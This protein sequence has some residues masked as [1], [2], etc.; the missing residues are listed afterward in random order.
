M[1]GPWEDYQSIASNSDNSGPWND[2]KS[3]D[4]G[5]NPQAAVQGFGQFATAGYLPELTSAAGKLMTKILPDP[6]ADIDA[7]LRAQGTNIQQAPYQGVTTDESRALQ[8]NLASQSPGSYYGGGALGAVA[9][10]PAFGAALKGMGL[11]KNLPTAA[12]ALSTLPEDASLLAKAGTY[13]ANLGSRAIQAGKEGVVLGALQNPNTNP[14]EQGVNPG[15]RIMNAATSGVISSAIPAVGD[16]IKGT[17]QAIKSGTQWGLTK[18]LS[19]IGG[20]NPDTINEYAQYA[21]RI[22]S[23]PNVEQLKQTSDEFV[24]KLAADVDAKK[25]SQQQAQ[26]AYNGFKNDLQDAYKTLTYDARD[27]ITSAKQTLQDTHNT[28]IQ[29]I[30]NDVYDSVNQ[31]RSDVKQGSANA[32]KTLG[33]SNAMVDLAP[34]YASID[35]SISNLK[36]ANTD[37]ALSAAQALQNYKDR[38]VSKFGDKIPAP[39]A[40]PVIQGL[41]K[42]TSYNSNPST[43][44]DVRN[45]AFKGIRG[46]LDETLKSAVPEYG[47]AMVP[48]AQDTALL[49]QVQPFG[50]KQTAVGLLNRLDNPNQFQ[51]K[52]ALQQL[53]SKYNTD[54]VSAANPQNLPEYRLLQKAQTNLKNL[55]P[56]RI[57]QNVEDTLASSRQKAQLEATQQGLSQ[58]QEKLA[59]FQSLAPN[60]AGQT[61]AQ[62]KLLQLGKG[63]NIELTDMFQQLGKLTDTDFVQAMKDQNTLAAFQKGAT[64]GSRN[65][66]LGGIVG[67]V[68]GGLH[69]AAYGGAAGRVVDQWGPAITKKVLD[70]ALTAAKSPVGQIVQTISNTSLPQPLKQQM[71]TGFQQYLA[72]KNASEQPVKG[73]A[74][75]AQQGITNLGITDHGMISKMLQDPKAKQLLIQASDLTP[76]TPAYK[77]VQNQIQKGWGN[78]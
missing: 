37:E 60:N 21:D 30:A 6:S 68:I 63:K 61:Q 75:W 3:S 26:Q 51:N 57:A 32:V 36:K 2:Y 56:N 48:V 44:D 64:N 29:N 10:A 9:S 38:T 20:V 16:I 15:Q 49:K 28:N 47:D 72:Q 70:V 74:K 34:T 22:N 45:A 59:P 40:K 66:L 13:A 55:R 41:D 14:G 8:K 62:Q 42:I 19:N 67:G 4:S 78:Q 50:D 5:V 71:I 65:T 25:L 24:G 18:A 7:R 33:N 1:A 77:A 12:Q 54:F 53:G 43:F 46:T 11:A 31:L 23:A 69:G 52:S 39:D 27:A 58:A 17:T 35:E 73:E 76:N